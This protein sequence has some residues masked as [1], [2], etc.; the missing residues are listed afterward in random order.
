MSFFNYNFVLFF[1]SG[2]ANVN[3]S[4]S[5]EAM[6]S[7]TSPRLRRRNLAGTAN[8]VNSLPVNVPASAASW[9]AQRYPSSPSSDR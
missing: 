2:L 5:E 4:A 6:L 7:D 8:D 3:S 9:A 1:A